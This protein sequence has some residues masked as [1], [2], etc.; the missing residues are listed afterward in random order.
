MENKR[1][2]QSL[3]DDDLLQRLAELL[4]QSRRVESDLVAHIGE[5]DERR[6][7]AREAA[8]SMFVY[9]TQVLHLSDAEAYLRIAVARAARAHPMLLAM[10][11][12][13]RLHLTGIGK[14][15]PHL[16]PD[17]A[18]ALLKRATHRS[19]RQ[20]EELVAELAPQPDV[21]ASIRRLPERK[22]AFRPATLLGPDPVGVPVIELRPDGVPTS[23]RVQ[24]RSPLV[25]TPLAQASPLQPTPLQ[26]TPEPRLCNQ[27]LYNQRRCN[28]W[29]STGTRC[30]SQP[31]RSFVTSW[32]DSRS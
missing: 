23:A 2:L 19:K 15:A 26:P 24:A 11:E 3:S 30:S 6:L 29:P 7:Y 25:Q 10:L 8:S 31:A 5:V 27:R 21:P 12:D 20:I 32:S 28:P 1:P 14:L 16:T 4:R 13:G 17:N 18:E 9:C 22:T